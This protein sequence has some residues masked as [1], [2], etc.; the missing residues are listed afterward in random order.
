[1]LLKT[2]LFHSFNGSKYSIVCIY[3]IFICSSADEHLS[4]FHI[5]AVVNIAAVKIRVH[6][7]LNWAPTN[8]G[9]PSFHV[10]YFCL[11]I[12][13]TGFSGQEYWSGLSFP[14]PVD[15]VLSELSTMIHPCWVA[16]H[17][18]AHSFIELDKAVVHVISLVS[19]LWLWFSVSALW[20][21]RIRGLWNGRLWLR[22]KLGLVLMG[23]AVLSKSLIQFSVDGR[24]C[25]PSLLFDLRPNYGGGDEDN[26]D[27][28]GSKITAD[29]DCSHEI[30]RRLLL[31]AK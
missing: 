31:E 4:C 15:H 18:T 24:G 17:G 25:V 21:R 14:S 9:G 2:A 29:G 28:L 13:F 30:K 16:L 23:G 19:F 6:V 22:G 1:M 12:L 26:G 11:F 8:L 20:W 10:L 3:C 27:L 7:S 5:L